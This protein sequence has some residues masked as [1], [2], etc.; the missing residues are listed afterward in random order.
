MVYETPG[1]IQPGDRWMG[2]RTDTG[3]SVVSFR[4]T[5]SKQWS[6]KIVRNCIFQIL[7]SNIELAW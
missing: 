5:L 4:F 7:K 2:R 1:Y 3:A 6:K